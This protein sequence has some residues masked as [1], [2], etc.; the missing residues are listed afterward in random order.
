MSIYCHFQ[1]SE[2]CHSDLPISHADGGGDGDGDGDG[3]GVDGDGD[4]GGGM[5]IP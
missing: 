5:Y 1:C 3:D 4:G 2:C